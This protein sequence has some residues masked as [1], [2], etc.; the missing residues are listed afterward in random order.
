MKLCTVYGTTLRVHPLFPLLCLPFLLTGQGE[1]LLAYGAALALHEAG[2]VGAA[3][4]LR[5]PVS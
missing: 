1:M 4:R 5:H 2:H 3:V